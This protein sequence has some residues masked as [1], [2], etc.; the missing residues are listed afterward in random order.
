M[1][2]DVPVGTAR[3]RVASEVK[4]AKD[5]KKTKNGNMKRRREGGDRRNRAKGI[6]RKG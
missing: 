6:R 2:V 1:L 3:R 4:M 5:H